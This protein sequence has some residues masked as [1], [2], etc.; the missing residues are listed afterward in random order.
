MPNVYAGRAASKSNI[1]LIVSVHGM[2]APEAL[3]RSSR[4]KRLFWSTVQGPAYSNVAVWHATSQAEAYS[5]RRFGIE[6]PIAIIPNG[7]DIPPVVADHRADKPHRS[8]L[9]LSR[10]HPHKGLT[11]LIRAWGKVA[12]ERP[13]WRLVIAGDGDYR[14]LSELRQLIQSI[15]AP[16]INLVGRVEGQERDRLYAES[17]LFVLPSK[18]E[19]FGLVIA[20]ALAIGVPVIVSKGTPW[21][22][23]ERQ[24][25]GWWT[26]SDFHA[27]A[28]TILHATELSVVER[29]SMGERGRSWM[30]ADFGWTSV[31]ERMIN[32][33]TW[34]LGNRERPD[35][36]V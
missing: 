25:C 1:P 16:R 12:T 33:Y 7:V 10:I 17:D 5:I 36:I 31:T 29:K 2:L 8:L 23:V 30:S 21:Q 13:E 4:I 27:L 3:A 28:S 19:N 15:A 20:E 35:F 6:A 34:I 11:E 24:G 22:E 9:F 14:Y 18:S 26:S 32:V